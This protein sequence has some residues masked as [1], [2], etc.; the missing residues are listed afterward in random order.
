MNKTLEL[1]DVYISLQKS[2]H[3]NYAITE[4]KTPT[5]EELLRIFSY[6]NPESKALFMFQLTSGQRIE[7]VI[8]TTFDNIDMT[9]D[10]PKIYYPQ[11]KQKYWVKTP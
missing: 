11:A 6:S 4:T 10:C 3:G 2:G 1:D 9:K 8:N 7:Q 5:R